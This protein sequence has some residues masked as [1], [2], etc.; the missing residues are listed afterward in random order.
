LQETTDLPKYAVFLRREESGYLIGF[1]R[2]VWI[3]G[4]KRGF[5]ERDGFLGSI[6]PISPL[7]ADKS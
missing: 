7:F 3:L 2:D 6:E 5:L 1:Y 4:R